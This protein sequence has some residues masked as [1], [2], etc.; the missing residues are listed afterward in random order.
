MIGRMQA[1]HVEAIQL[2]QAR[3]EPM[4]VVSEASAEAGRGLAG[5]QRVYGLRAPGTQITFVSAEDVETMVAETGIPLEPLETRRNVVT[6]GIA[7]NGLIGRRFRVGNALC[8]GVKPCTPC[9]HLESQ[10]RPG[11]RSGLSGRGGLR[12]DILESGRI[13]VGDSIELL[14]DG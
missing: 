3:D 12:A 9:N 10:T 8:A 2:H 1:G 11:V 6:R 14:P 5:D 7:L 13:R 4:S